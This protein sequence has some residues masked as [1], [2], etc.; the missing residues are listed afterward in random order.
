MNLKLKII[1]ILFSILMVIL[2]GIKIRNDLN[3]KNNIEQKTKEIFSSMNTSSFAKI[4]KYIV[5]GTNFNLEG[6]IEIPQISKISVSKVNL[7]V[8]D[9]NG[10]QKILKASYKYSDGVLDFS[11]IEEINNGINLEKLNSEKY[12]F[13]IEVI[14]SNN[15]IYNYSLKNETEYGDIV[16]YTITKNN[17][18][19]VINIGFNEYNDISYM[20]AE[21]SDIENLPDD[22]YDIVID[23]SHGGK[24]TGAK[25][26]EYNEADIVLDCSNILKAQLEEMGY[27]V[28]VTRDETMGKDV[29]TTL[30]MY[31]DDGRVNIA[32]NT[33]AKI[34]ISLHIDKG[35]KN[36]SGVEIY[37]PCLSNLN[38]AK[39][40]ADNIVKYANTSYSS[41]DLYKEDDG[42]YVRNYRTWDILEQKNAAIRNKYEPYNITTSTPFLYMIRECGG[43]ATNAFVDGRNKVYGKN[44]F[45]NSNIGIETYVVEL[46][47]MI[48]NKDLEN[49]VNH[50]DLYMKG[51]SES[52]QNYYNIKN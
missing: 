19:K 23:A 11:T 43:I 40:M 45:M 48:N 8:Q 46:G 6:K 37:A 35:S 25:N 3:P 50:S 41:S 27:K 5:Y 1:V 10:E 24:D 52:I 28:F 12:F 44:N 36:D 31:D 2:V 4:T 13:F 16:Y 39:S 14:F 18:N 21:I 51:I 38:F 22:I 29:D 47:N 33:H 34:L 20:G 7:I 15:E 9:L 49:V 17:T 26:G 42:V 32:N 30:N